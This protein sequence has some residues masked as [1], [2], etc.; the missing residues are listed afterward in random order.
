VVYRRSELSKHTID[1]DCPHQ[2]ALSVYCC[3]G[4]NYVAI[5]LFCD[6]ERLAVPARASFYRDGTE[7]T[8]FCFGECEHAELFRERFGGEFLDPKDRPNW[9]GSRR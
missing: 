2:V 5:H 6:C 4:G 7:M 3:T 9:P 1:R 8:V